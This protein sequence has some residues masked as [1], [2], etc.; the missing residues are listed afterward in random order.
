MILTPRHVTERM[1][2]TAMVVLSANRRGAAGPFRE[3]PID[4]ALLKLVA[5]KEF[6]TCPAWVP[7]S[8][9]ARVL[10]S[11]TDGVVASR[12]FG[13]G[14]SLVAVNI[15]RV[16]ESSI[17]VEPRSQTDAISK[18]MSGSLLL[19]GG[20][21]AGM[22]Y[23]A[24]DERAGTAYRLDYIERIVGPVFA[25]ADPASKPVDPRAAMDILERA[26][27]K[28]DGSQMMQVQALEQLLGLGNKFNATDF[29]GVW[30]AK[31]RLDG[32]TITQ[33]NFLL[34]DLTEVSAIKADLSGTQFGFVAAEN[35][36]FDSAN[37]SGSRSPFISAQRS[38]WRTANL[39]G[40]NFWGADLRGA[41]FR[42]ADLRSTAFAFADLRGARF[43]GADLRGAYLTGAVLDSA[44]FDGATFGETNVL[45]ASFH[46]TALTAVQRRGACR[47]GGFGSQMPWTVRFIEERPDPTMSQG[48]R[49]E[50]KGYIGHPLVN[51]SDRSLPLCTSATINAGRFHA[52]VP[53]EV[54]YYFSSLLLDV[55]TR[56]QAIRARVQAQ[57]AAVLPRLQLEHNLRDTA[58]LAQFAADL[59]KRA[60]TARVSGTGIGEL[61]R[62][63]LP[64]L[65]TRA[66]AW[67]PDSATWEEIAL[68]RW[69]EEIGNPVDQRTADSVKA[70]DAFFPFNV[71]WNELPPTDRVGLYRA[72]VMQMANMPKA[73]FSCGQGGTVV[74]EATGDSV[75]LALEFGYCGNF[76][77]AVG[78]AGEQW[79]AT[80]APTLQSTG[81][82]ID[83]VVAIA[84]NIYG[85]EMVLLALP[86]AAAEYGLRVPDR[87]FNG[88]VGVA[89]DFMLDRT[90]VLRTR[91]GTSVAVIVARPTRSTIGGETEPG[92]FPLRQMGRRRA[93]H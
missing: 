36:R 13:G 22:L 41:D 30:L 47:H 9:L 45:G 74:P 88:G 77:Y 76:G 15:R 83:R 32:G 8:T 68:S 38:S 25:T 52:D 5:P 84:Q 21:P 87:T 10:D 35:A 60:S 58:R 24:T 23:E 54:Q 67:K 37:V 93:P 70:R 12:D 14:R 69:R 18:G 26:I 19:V 81:I 40:S 33:A 56:R 34:S 73:A 82:D 4:L 2:N 78:K 63:T 17:V 80:L 91:S 11:A 48:T 61:S 16:D 43:E 28:K 27:T 65:L 57:A 86:E 55:G 39:S 64:M 71:P 62:V 6:G 3:T 1:A 20:I 90:L 50:E 89:T 46:G 72:Y 51:F 66:G 7:D 44:H 53:S 79:K 31:A 42:G 75:W 49:F 85:L 92:A 29:S 59:R